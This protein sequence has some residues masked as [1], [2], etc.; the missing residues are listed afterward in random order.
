MNLAGQGKSIGNCGRQCFFLPRSATNPVSAVFSSRQASM[1]PVY[2]AFPRQQ[3]T[4]R[5]FSP[6]F[7]LFFLCRLIF[8]FIFASSTGKSYICPCNVLL[9]TT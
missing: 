9:H 3:A 7:H 5:L 6:L 1:I 2:N 8:R 4:E